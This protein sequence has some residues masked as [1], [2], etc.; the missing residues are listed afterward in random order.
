[1][2]RIV[3]AFKNMTLNARGADK[4]LNALIAKNEIWRAIGLMTSNEREVDNAIREYN[5]QTHPVMMRPNKYRDDD[6]PYITEKLPRTRAR[7]INEIELFFLLGKPIEWTLKKGDEEAYELFVDFLSD[8]HFDSKIRQIKRLAG[9]EI[10]AAL[11]FNLTND[12]GKMRSNEFVVSRSRGYKLR[13]MFDQY[14]DLVAL[15]YGYRLKENGKNV[16]HYD[17]LTK[18]FTHYCSLG[19]RGWLVETYKNITGKINAIY[20]TQK[21]AWDGAVPRIEREELL[22]SKVADTNNYF[23]DPM[24]AATADVI[25]SLADPD[26]P[27]R[28][29]QLGGEKSKFE[30]INPPQNSNTREAEK[31]NLES[32][33]LFDTFTPDFSYNNMKGLGTLSGAAMH[34]AL[35]LG[36][37][38]RDILKETY[39]EM[40]Q[41]FVNVVKAILKI[42]RPDLERKIEEM[43]ITFKFA[44]PF[45]EDKRQEWQIIAQIYSAGIISLETAVKMLA[46]TNAPEEEMARIVQSGKQGEK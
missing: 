15:A 36:Y 10:E 3:N 26:K 21:K 29:I 4:E 33:I 28:L 25:D 38:K 20:F 46:L 32:S 43:R 11:V 37:I 44:E 6:E 39:G 17:I 27:G 9:S 23:A 30:Y 40:L 12:N 31:T 41:R 5:P 34:N 45:M 2:N 42:R 22:D 35:I 8:M 14:G 18:D 13:T 19:E 24:A 1:M 7:Y 16:L